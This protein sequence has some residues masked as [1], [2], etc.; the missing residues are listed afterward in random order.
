MRATIYLKI[1]SSDVCLNEFSGQT[2]P[3]EITKFECLLDVDA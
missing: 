3:H 2:L 1:V